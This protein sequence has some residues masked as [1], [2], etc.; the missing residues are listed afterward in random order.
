MRPNTGQK[1]SRVDC[2]SIIQ[3]RN[4]EQISCSCTLL[5]ARCLCQLWENAPLMEQQRPNTPL[6]FDF[7][8]TALLTTTS[9]DQS[10]SAMAMW[11][12]E[13][14]QYCPPHTHTPPGI[15]YWRSPRT[16]WKCQDCPTL[17][18]TMVTQK[19]IVYVST[20]SFTFIPFS[21]EWKWQYTGYRLDKLHNIH[22]I[23]IPLL[24]GHGTGHWPRYWPLSVLPDLKK[25]VL[26]LG[27]RW[28]YERLCVVKVT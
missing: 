3:Y 7:S 16:F 26:F 1:Y 17:V 8:C 21:L 22:T 6:V 10:N 9:Y 23:L 12:L 27:C 24:L 25:A 15:A 13:R 11:A 18:A 19:Q 4:L 5:S 14:Q 28:G 20:D 2:V